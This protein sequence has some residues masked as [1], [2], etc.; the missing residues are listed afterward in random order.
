MG[1]LRDRMDADLRLAGRSEST[2]RHYL[3]CAR[4]FVKHFMRPAETMGQA[5]V[6]QFLLHL[7]DEAKVS[8]GRYLQYLGALKFLYGVTLGRP[9]VVAGIPWPRVLRPAP[10]VLTRPEVLRIFEAAPSDYWRTFFVTAY[11]TGMRRMEVAAL[12]HADID[13]AAGLIRVRCGK[14]GKNRVVMLDPTLHKTLRDHWRVHRLPGP[15]VFPARAAWG[16]S[17]LPVTLRDATTAFHKAA[18]VARIQRKVTLHGLRHAFATH[19][20]EDGVDLAVLQ[21]LLGH[22]H[23]ETTTRYTQVRTDL[24]RSTPSPLAKLPV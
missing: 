12:Q 20:L 19:S 22:E 10:D 7:A 15:W 14:G 21:Q 24:I 23:V 4:L 11:A 8:V 1:H 5:E 9:E 3:S 2:R 17:G 18:Q 16:W 6:R 13:A